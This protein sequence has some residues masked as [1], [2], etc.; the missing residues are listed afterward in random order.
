MVGWLVQFW[1]VFNGILFQNSAT[2][3]CFHTDK[4]KV[5]NLNSAEHTNVRK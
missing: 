1:L 3:V 4:E 2:T 5:K